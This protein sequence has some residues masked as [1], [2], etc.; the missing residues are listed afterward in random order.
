[1]G[2]DRPRGLTPI[3]RIEG[4][5][6]DPGRLPPGDQDEPPATPVAPEPQPVRVR[7][8]RH[9]WQRI[10]RGDTEIETEL[11]AETETWFD[12]TPKQMPACLP[13]PGSVG[14]RIRSNLTPGMLS[15]SIVRPLRW[16]PITEKRVDAARHHDHGEVQ[17]KNQP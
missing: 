1:V 4:S 17:R 7:T 8:G 6:P 2:A 11:E 13:P 5:V 14:V 12:D 16:L 9:W 3:I 10:R 15:A